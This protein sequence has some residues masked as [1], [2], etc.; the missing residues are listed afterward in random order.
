[1]FII[2]NDITGHVWYA[3]R[4]EAWLFAKLDVNLC[5]YTIMRAGG[6][7]HGLMPSEI[8]A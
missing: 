5:Q 1:M 6:T 7:P 4:F 3:S 2:R 8:L